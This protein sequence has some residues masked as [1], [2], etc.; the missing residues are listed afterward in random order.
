MVYSGKGMRRKPKL[1]T[2]PVEYA[3]P[4]DGFF[5][6]KDPVGF[7]QAINLRMRR[8]IK[9]PEE[10]EFDCG[11][12]FA[13]CSRP[14]ANSRKVDGLFTDLVLPDDEDIIRENLLLWRAT[15]CM[16]LESAPY[17]KWGKWRRLLWVREGGGKLIF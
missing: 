2:V 4:S 13:P 11:L 15:G 1:F 17:R 3:R 12:W 6:V 14:R 10:A 9:D 8:E 5:S 7:R 16:R